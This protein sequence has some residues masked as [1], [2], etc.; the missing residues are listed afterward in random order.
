M[1][2]KFKIQN[3]VSFDTCMCGWNHHH[4]QDKFPS[5]SKFHM[6]FWGLSFPGPL[7]PGNQWF[8]LH[9][10][11]SVCIFQDFCVNRITHTIYVNRMYSGLRFLSLSLMTIRMGTF[12]VWVL[13]CWT[14]FHY[15]YTPPYV[16]PFNCGCTIVIKT[17]AC[18]LSHIRRGWLFATPRTV[19][20]Q[21][22]LS[23]GLSRQ[24]YWSGLSYSPPWDLPD[25][26]IEP[27]SHT[28]TCTG[29][30]GLYN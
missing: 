10:C 3:S 16:Y 21:T 24:E 1:S 4:N 17:C 13:Y 8:A 29:Q 15:M 12:D 9:H 22:P 6:P 7:V 19:A 11:R 27:V 28:S 5:F 25:P 14:V 30:Q 18:V 2:F 23:M 20:Y 26:G